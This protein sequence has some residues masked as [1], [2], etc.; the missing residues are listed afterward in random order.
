MKNKLF[1]AAIIA[2]ACIVGARGDS[3]YW[4]TNP[5]SLLMANVPQLI[6]SNNSG[7]P[8]L[9]ISNRPYVYFKGGSFVVRVTDDEWRAITNHFY[10]NIQTNSIT[11]YP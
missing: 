2:A 10:E 3:D 9:I 5:Q 7:T 4:K 6:I 1:I 11:F 8:F